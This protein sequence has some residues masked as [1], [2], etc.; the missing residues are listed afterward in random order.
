[1]EAF[2][3]DYVCADDDGRRLYVPRTGSTARVG[4]YDLDTKTGRIILIA[5]E[6]GPPPTDNNAH[7][8]P[9]RFSRGPMVSGSFSVLVVGK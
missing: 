3:F 1:M 5:A 8:P 9:G 2:I 4:L 6:F 7:A